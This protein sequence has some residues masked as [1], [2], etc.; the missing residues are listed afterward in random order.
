MAIRI[1]KSTGARDR[2][3]IYIYWN[4]EQVIDPLFLIQ[5]TCQ[6]TLLNV[7]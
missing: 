6:L 4:V 1:L 2:I 5:I 3:R 7:V